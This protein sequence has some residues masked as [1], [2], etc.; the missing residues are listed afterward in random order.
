MVTKNG[1]DYK[2]VWELDGKFF[3]LADLMTNDW[4]IIY[5]GTELWNQDGRG[6]VEVGYLD[7]GPKTPMKE[8]KNM[9]SRFRVM[10][11]DGDDTYSYAIF[12]RDS[13]RGMSSPIYYYPQPIV[14]GM[15]YHEAWARKKLMDADDKLIKSTVK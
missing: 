3:V 12:Y 7:P 13:V 1:I 11:F 9:K 14:S 8:N 6:Y 2:G 10:K 15:S 5:K 4:N